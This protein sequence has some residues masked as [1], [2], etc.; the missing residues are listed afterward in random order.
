[1]YWKKAKNNIQKKQ[2][3]KPREKVIVRKNMQKKHARKTKQK[4][5]EKYSFRH[6]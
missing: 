2:A 3:K 6:R 4:R 1:M 5:G